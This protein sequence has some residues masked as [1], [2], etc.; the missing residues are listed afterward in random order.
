MTG[1]VEVK[2]TRGMLLLFYSRFAFFSNITCV[3]RLEQTEHSD[4]ILFLEFLSV[5]VLHMCKDNLCM[6]KKS[7]TDK[8]NVDKREA[9][10]SNA[11]HVM[12]NDCNRHLDK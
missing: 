4:L 10:K 9:G 1:Y 11:N 6:L 7:R 2:K 8:R 3:I 12:T 5:V